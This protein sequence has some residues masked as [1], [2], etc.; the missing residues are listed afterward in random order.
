MDVESGV[1]RLRLYR[2]GKP[3]NSPYGLDYKQRNVL[4]TARL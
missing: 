3:K 2:A 4:P 1:E